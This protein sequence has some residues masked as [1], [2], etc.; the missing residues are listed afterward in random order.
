MLG[1]GPSNDELL[2][3]KYKFIFCATCLNK[4]THPYTL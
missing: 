2:R 4:N 3:E 1:L